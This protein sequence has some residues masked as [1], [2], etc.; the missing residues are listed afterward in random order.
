MSICV[1][2]VA[3]MIMESNNPIGG[4]PPASDNWFVVKNKGDIPQDF[5]RG[6][7]GKWIF[8]YYKLGEGNPLSG[9]RMIR[10]ERKNDVTVPAGW[11]KIDK[12][13]KAG[14]GGQF[15]YLC[16]ICTPGA[17]RIKMLKA[18]CGDSVESAVKDFNHGDI[19]V[20]QDVNEG[21]HGKFIYL[22]YTY[23]D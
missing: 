21:V 16:K 22:G 3:V 2:D 17:P 1:T 11:T 15:I 13:L 18:G 19:V 14:A 9:L 5:N 20:M 4:G 7:H 10:S 8:V 23:D 12:D 6:V